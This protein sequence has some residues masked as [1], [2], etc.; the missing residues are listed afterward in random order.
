M[1]AQQIELT[2]SSMSEIETLELEK[3][4]AEI[5]LIMAVERY[6][7]VGTPEEVLSIVNGNL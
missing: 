6:L 4:E 3:S 5:I 7:K 1:D 2:S